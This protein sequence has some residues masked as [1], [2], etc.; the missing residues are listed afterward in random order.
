ME[1]PQINVLSKIDLMEKYGKLQFNVDYYTE[2]LELEYLL[3]NLDRDVSTQKYQKLNAALIG[4]I[5]D[6]SLVSFV[7]LNVK[8]EKLLQNVQSAVDK[9]NGY[10]FGTDSEAFEPAV[11]VPVPGKTDRWEGEDEEEPVKDSWEDEEDGTSKES[12]NKVSEGTGTK[13]K[14]KKLE[15][16]IAEKERKK[17]EELEKKRQEE[18][19]DSLKSMT[20][21]ERLGEKLRL[22]K[23]QEEADLQLAREA[24]GTTEQAKAGSIDH[25]KPQTK[26]EFTEFSKAIMKKVSEFQGQDQYSEFVESLIQEL[27]LTLELDPLKKVHSAVKALLDE[28]AKI[29]KATKAK[30]GK[31]KGATLKMDKA[32]DVYGGDDLADYDD[33]M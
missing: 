5:E 2:V 28:K 10:V 23:I 26:E 33:F 12:E 31:G 18:E 19:E 15:E 6:Y 11:A 4:I 20:P 21:E 25:A 22:Q 1:L 30:K 8:D 3:D 32:I 29:S 14:K 9:A 17:R 16:I 13:K 7:A 27:C 24:F